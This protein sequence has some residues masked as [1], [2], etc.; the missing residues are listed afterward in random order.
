MVLP[1]AFR[2]F[3][4]ER[5][6][7]CLENRFAGANGKDSKKGFGVSPKLFSVLSFGYKREDKN[8]LPRREVRLPQ[9][10]R[11]F[12]MTGFNIPKACRTAPH[13]SANADTVTLAVPEKRIGCSALFLA[14][15]DRGA[16]KSS[17]YRPQDAL[18][19]YAPKGEG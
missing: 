1:F 14:F 3:Y 11:A 16:I 5:G 15:F 13:P 19:F 9:A 6:C 17:L 10:L 2:S 18:G 8:N 12:A 4:P 7:P